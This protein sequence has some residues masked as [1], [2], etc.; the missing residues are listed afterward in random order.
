MEERVTHVSRGAVHLG[1][2]AVEELCRGGGL[3]K[4]KIG[5]SGVGFRV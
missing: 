4:R 5:E 1:E 2:A 3:R